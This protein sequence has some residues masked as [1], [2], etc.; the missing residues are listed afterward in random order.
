MTFREK[1]DGI[2]VEIENMVKERKQQREI[3]EIICAKNIIPSYT[4]G[5]VFQFITGE[6]FISYIKKRRMIAALKYKVDNDKTLEATVEEFDYSDVPT[7]SKLCKRLFN[8]SPSEISEEFLSSMVPLKLEEILKEQNNMEVQNIPVDNN[9]YFFGVPQEDYNKIKKAMELNSLYQ[10]TDSQA[11]LAYSLSEESGSSLEAA[12]EF[13]DELMIQEEPIYNLIGD[14]T[15]TDEE[16]QQFF[17]CVNYDM[18]RNESMREIRVLRQNGIK[19]IRRLSDEFWGIYLGPVNQQEVFEINDIIALS[20]KINQKKMSAEEC[21]DFLMWAINCG[22]DIVDIIED[23]EILEKKRK[24]EVAE[25]SAPFSMADV[26][27]EINECERA[28]I[29]ELDEEEY[30]SKYE[31]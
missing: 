1:Y 11:N 8:L 7:F 17:L 6:G 10:F 19:D 5:D 16:R 29:W 25:L 27:M 12:F 2:I 9:T 14:L 31:L 23:F 30:Y 21:N 22:Y 18:S 24:K 20:K 26:L 4:L 13:L 15:I 3:S 28:S